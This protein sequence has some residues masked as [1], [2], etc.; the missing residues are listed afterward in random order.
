MSPVSTWTAGAVTVESTLSVDGQLADEWVFEESFIDDQVCKNSNV[1]CNYLMHSL[2]HC[3][4]VAFNKNQ[5]TMEPQTFE[6]I[7]PDHLQALL[8]PLHAGRDSDWDLHSSKQ[9]KNTQ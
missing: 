4:A 1:T 2:Q 3:V 9:H 5:S 7:K 8:N 6:H